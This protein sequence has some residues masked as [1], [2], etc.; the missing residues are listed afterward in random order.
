MANG[1]P[2]PQTA[3]RSAWS[4]RYP[5]EPCQGGLGCSL[6]CSTGSASVAL[7][8]ASGTVNV[9]VITNTGQNFAFVRLG[10]NTVVA[11]T[12]CM[13]VPPGGAVTCS[14]L[15]DGNVLPTNIAGVTAS[16]TTTIQVSLG[17]GN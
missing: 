11:T 15:N 5:F 4:S 8:G 10:D 1:T 6:S 7:V 13:A 16:G 17:Y 12:A 3:A 14:I 9:A 2:G